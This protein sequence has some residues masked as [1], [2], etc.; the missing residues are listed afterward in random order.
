MV[1][2]DLDHINRNLKKISRD[3]KLFVKDFV[4]KRV[5][6]EPP[7]RNVL[8]L[9][10][11]HYEREVHLDSDQGLSQIV[12]PVQVKQPLIQSVSKEL[13]TLSKNPDL[14]IVNLTDYNNQLYQFTK[15]YNVNSFKV[16][17]EYIWPYIR[18]H[19]LVNLY[20]TWRGRESYK[21]LNPLALSTAHFSKFTQYTRDYSIASIDAKSFDNLENEETNIL[22]VCQHSGFGRTEIDG[23]IYHRLIDPLFEVAST[24][25]SSKK[26]EFIS[27]PN[28]NFIDI[29]HKYKYK[30]LSILPPE[31]QKVGYHNRC[32]YD[33]SFFINFKGLFTT[34]IPVNRH[35]LNSV[36]DYEM[37]TREWMLTVLK[38]IKPKVIFLTSFHYHA[39]LIS[40]ANELGIL[41]IDIQ[42][43][44]QAG[45]GILYNHHEEIPEKGYQSYPD[46]FAVWGNKE[47]KNI[48]RNFPNKG[49]KAI[50]LGNP[51]LNKLEEFEYEFSDY[52][53]K[54][55]GSEKRLIGLIVLQDQEKIQDLYKNIIKSTEGQVFWLVRHHPTSRKFFKANDFI[56]GLIND[57]VL[58]DESIDQANIR[59]LFDKVNFTLSEGSALAYEASQYG[60]KNFVFSDYAAKN[61]ADE[62]ET[63]SFYYVHDVDSFNS[64]FNTIDF[65]SKVNEYLPF[66]NVNVCDFIKETLEISNRKNIPRNPFVFTNEILIKQFQDNVGAKLDLINNYLADGYKI[67]AVEVFYELRELL[68][69]A[70]AIAKL[71]D[72]EHEY[73]A[74]ESR[75]FKNIINSEFGEENQDVFMVADSLGLPRPN[76][77]VRN[78]FGAKTTTAWHFNQ[79]AL[80]QINGHKMG[81]W[82]QRYL[83]TSRLIDS[84]SKIVGHLENKHLIVHLGLNDS[85]E[86]IFLEHQRLGMDL[87]EINV[88]K[89]II[90]FGKKYRKDI[91]SNQYEFNYVSPDQFR[92][93][94][95]EIINLANEEGASSISFVNIISF[96][97]SH[98]INT[99]RSFINT[100]KYNE[101]ISSVVNTNDN[102]YLIDL[103]STFIQEGKDNCMLEDNMHLSSIGHETLSN[104]ILT[105]LDGGVKLEYT[106]A[107]IGVGQLGSRYLQGVKKIN[108]KNRS[109][110]L[111]LVE[112]DKKARMLAITRFNEI[113]KNN[114]TSITVEFCEDIA[115]L[116]NNLDLVIIATAAEIRAE[117][118]RELLLQKTFK[119]VILEKVLFQKLEDY[120]EF[121]D[122]FSNLDINVWVNHPR[123][124]FSFYK[125]IV[126]DI[127]K[128]KFINFSVSGINWGLA[129]NGL[130]FLD[131][132]LFLQQS[133]S[134]NCPNVNLHIDAEQVLP[135]K[136]KGCYEVFGNLNGKI[137][138]ASVNLDCRH[139]DDNRVDTIININ[140][141]TIRFCIDEARG[142]VSY[143][144]I[145]NDWKWVQEKIAIIEH[146]SDLT[147]HIVEDILVNSRCNLPTYKDACLLHEPFIEVVLG[148]L[149]SEVN[150]T[151]TTCLI[152]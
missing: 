72:N 20:A 17:D 49:H 146:Q 78:D 90:D 152:S 8:N 70:P 18:N 64:I 139:T 56:N 10:T 93:N 16:G 53:T 11:K 122:K 37:H 44:L 104:E 131:L 102:A 148:T 23:E 105:K 52:V 30:T 143:A 38:Q 55:L 46:Y 138:K 48:E 27:N 97:K 1:K 7:F 132:I 107:L 65:D 144:S 2:L 101:I 77:T 3:P 117:I 89:E 19:M 113:A 147:P 54:K 137:G 63:D 61:F 40:A 127:S 126:G 125:N 87:L 81:I 121:R 41:T 67:K 95:Q 108:L 79:N 98:E 115:S 47:L 50:L 82:A 51:W 84:W 109:L 86:R 92:S 15:R 24:I 29:W 80:S 12:K 5:S 114:N 66:A 150:D 42:H 120:I 75:I 62:I 85:S 36:V 28:I 142:E 76:E 21:Q 22:F 111:Q 43:G 119:N 100:Q 9:I 130:H 145:T 140:T 103:E 91:I 83:T 129:C 74:K 123:R 94:L 25:T 136:R 116:S 135:A 34:Q 134:E 6:N 118:L 58:I 32:T 69:Q 13:Q 99:P 73:F 124:E 31:F 141:D 149:K 4:N 68:G 14:K 110:R 57:Q 112:N 60:I 88:K 59:A 35:I 26:I 128:S 106:V 151:I 133:K 45:D 33:E 39:S 71:C 96:P